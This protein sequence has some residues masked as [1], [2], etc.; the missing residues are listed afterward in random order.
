MG[1]SD[2]LEVEEEVC[3]RKRR[4]Q[5]E[6]RGS[7]RECVEMVGDLEELDI[8]PF[9]YDH[10]RKAKVIGVGAFG[11]VL[12]V[13]VNGV[14]YAVKRVDT[15]SIESTRCLLKEVQMLSRYCNNSNNIVKFKGVFGGLEYYDN[16][17]PKE[18]FMLIEYLP[19]MDMKKFL[20]R[21][22][23][24]DHEYSFEEKLR[25]LLDVANALDALH[26]KNIIHGDLSLSNIIKL[27]PQYGGKCVLV[28]FGSSRKLSGETSESVSGTC[29]FL[30]PE[31]HE[32]DDNGTPSE[33]FVFGLIMFCVLADMIVPFDWTSR[34]S[35][36]ERVV[37]G[38]RPDKA[39]LP[40]FIAEN[41]AV[42]DLLDKCWFA[43][44]KTRPKISW[45]KNELIAIYEMYSKKNL[46]KN[47]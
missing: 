21:G 43:D 36:G 34:E 29:P 12:K 16:G 9:D 40:S 22:P 20:E 3:A 33:V 44:P 5:E 4:G 14:K 35:L 11:K 24:E 47:K 31:Q 41:F 17:N 10:I 32:I 45:V 28:D 2:W 15:K 6:E 38:E 18:I 19:G 25:D 27:K 7:R 39:L 8:L 13:T 37:D 1:G 23:H 26:A 30:S 46:P 42:T